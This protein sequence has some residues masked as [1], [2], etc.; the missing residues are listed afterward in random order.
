MRTR[1]LK[2]RVQDAPGEDAHFGTGSR[3]FERGQRTLSD[4]DLRDAGDT[5]RD[6]SV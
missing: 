6:K 3:R 5:W 1:R 4:R 2:S